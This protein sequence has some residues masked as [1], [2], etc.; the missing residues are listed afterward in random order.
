MEA[1][2]P[3][4]NDSAPLDVG[5]SW[6]GGPAEK[7]RAIEEWIAAKS[8]GLASYPALEPAGMSPDLIDEQPHDLLAFRTAHQR[9]AEKPAH[10]DWVIGT[11]AAAGVVTELDGPQKLSG[12]AT[13]LAHAIAAKLDGLPFMGRRPS[14]APSCAHRGEL[15]DLP[16]GVARRRTLDR[17]D[18][19][20]LTREDAFGA[21]WDEVAR[22]A[23]A[24]VV[25]VG[26]ELPVGDT[27]SSLAGLKGDE[28]NRSGGAFT[29]VRP[30]QEIAS[31]GA[32]VIV[33]RHD[34][35]AGGDV[36]ES[37]R[38]TSA[39]SGAMDMIFRLTRLGGDGRVTM[40]K[41][42]YVGRVRG[43]PETLIV[44]LTEAGY[45]VVGTAADV[46]RQE[47][48]E[49]LLE[50]CPTTRTRPSRCPAYGSRRT[51]TRAAQPDRWLARL[52]A[53]PPSERPPKPS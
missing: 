10:I 42:D 27:L 48:H 38:G 36:G 6:R 46:R 47:A 44:E 11:L 18:L 50:T 19:H 26:A 1:P 25:E 22:Q 45:T 28:E 3:E 14:Q 49:L 9:N 31:S 51:P 16:G 4:P 40:R 5:P 52:S 20:I 32:A 2:I 17:D 12:K 33:T 13:F 39:L 41:L 8:G 21:S 30:F 29:A 15:G 24:K 7:A 34:R 37:G 43:V 53:R 35:R 23:R